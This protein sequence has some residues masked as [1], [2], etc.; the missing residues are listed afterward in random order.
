MYLKKSFVAEF[1]LFKIRDYIFQLLPE[2]YF[3][4]NKLLFIPSKL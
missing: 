4:L 3:S 2:T 1:F